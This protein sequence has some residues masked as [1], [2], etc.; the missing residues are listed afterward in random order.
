MQNI[1]SQEETAH[2]NEKL[3]EALDP[4]NG[5]TT[6]QFMQEFNTDKLTSNIGAVN[7]NAN[8][9]VFKYSNDSDN[10]DPEYATDG[11]SGFD[12][13]ANLTEPVTLGVGERALIPTG[14]RF[15]I[16]PN[17]E[18]QVRPR[19]G[20]AY[21]KGITVLNSPG[22]VDADYRGDVGVILINH[23]QEEFVVEHGERIAQAVIATVVAKAIVNLNKVDSIDEDTERGAGGFGHTGTK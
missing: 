22:T 16:P 13:R 14:L 11:S 3:M 19:S 20:L 5:Y 9:L 10:L 2:M 17:F 12:L 1:L 7:P 4:T 23:G 15:E 8:K 18:I 6:E 21:K